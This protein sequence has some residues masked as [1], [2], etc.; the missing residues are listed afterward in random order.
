MLQVRNFCYTMFL[1]CGSLLSLLVTFLPWVLIY[2][3]PCHLLMLTWLKCVSH[4]VMPVFFCVYFGFTVCQ[5]ITWHTLHQTPPSGTLSGPVDQGQVCLEDTGL[6]S[7]WWSWSNRIRH[8]DRRLWH[9][10]HN[11]QYHIFKPLSKWLPNC[12]RHIEG[13]GSEEKG[14]QTFLKV[15]LSFFSFAQIKIRSSCKQPKL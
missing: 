4:S 2:F 3:W 6:D 7:H 1:I 5:S 13:S 10:S 15:I 9:S 8:E 11:T 12:R 14:T